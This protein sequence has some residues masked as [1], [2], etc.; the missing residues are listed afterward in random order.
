MHWRNF[1]QNKEL[2]LKIR[3]QQVLFLNLVTMLQPFI[4]VNRT[5]DR[6]RKSMK[7][8]KTRTLFFLSIRVIRKDEVN[9]ISLKKKAKYGFLSLIS[10]VLF[11]SLQLLKGLLK[12]A[13]KYLIMF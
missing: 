4:Q 9:S 7:M 5:S 2:P 13:Q 3:N 12:F 8:V 11:Q 10:F 6:S 1:E